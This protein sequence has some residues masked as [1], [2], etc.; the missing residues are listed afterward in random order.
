MDYASL[1]AFILPAYIAN[2]SPVVFSGRIPMDLGK[3][4]WDGKRLLGPG[5]TF[6]GLVAAIAIGTTTG[7]ILASANGVFLPQAE[8]KQ[9]ILAGFLLS[10]G[11]MAGDL[12]GSFIKRRLD[13]PPGAQHE[14]FD[15]LLFLGGALALT[16]TIYLPTWQEIVFLVVITYILHKTFNYLAHYLKLKNVPW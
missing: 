7:F 2:S 4:F 11:T 3:K 8:F 5:K 9:K 15:Q 13:I 12:L 14:F 10:A 6:K 16:S 1:I